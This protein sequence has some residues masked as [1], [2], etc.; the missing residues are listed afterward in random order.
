MALSPSPSTHC[1]WKFTGY[2]PNCHMLPWLQS[3]ETQAAFPRLRGIV[4]KELLYT[5][6]HCVPLAAE[7][8]WHAH[9]SK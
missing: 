5:V 3:P 1:A 4:L 2:Y 6:T 7:A 9:L 8:H